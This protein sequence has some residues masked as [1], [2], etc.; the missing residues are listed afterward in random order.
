MS[1]LK[2][3]EVSQPLAIADSVMRPL[4]LML[5]GFK[6][7]SIQETHFWHNQ[8]INQSQLD[9]SLSLVIAGDD[10]GATVTT[11][12]VFPFPMFHIPIL[13]G[14]RNY[15][16]L[17]VKSGVPYWHVGWFHRACT[18]G[19]RLLA[20]VQRLRITER[21]VRVL[22]QAVGFVTEYFAVGPAGEQ[23]RLIEADRGVLGDMRY[24]SIRLF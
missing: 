12:R 16:V 4:M 14:W 1:M 10:E 15:A 21:Q 5:G 17:E 7:D 22:T 24:P 11:N 20:T 6:R 2:V 23:L 8:P 3:D 18:P 13:G 19:S 9:S